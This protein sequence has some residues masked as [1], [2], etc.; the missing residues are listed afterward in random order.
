[1]RSFVIAALV[2]LA[3][4]VGLTACNSSSSKVSTNP[5]PGA[6]ATTPPSTSAPT[7]P[8]PTTTKPPTKKA[9]SSGGV[10]Y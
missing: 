7:T 8:A 5:S 1:M 10:S 9:P 3:A 6:T 2:G 4:T